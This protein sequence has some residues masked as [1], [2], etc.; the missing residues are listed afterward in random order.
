MAALIGLPDNFTENGGPG[1]GATVLVCLLAHNAFIVT[2]VREHLKRRAGV[3][4]EGVGSAAVMNEGHR[5]AWVRE[6]SSLDNRM[7]RHPEAV[8]GLRPIDAVS[9]SR[10]DATNPAADGGAEGEGEGLGEFLEE[11]AL[12]SATDTGSEVQ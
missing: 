8:N 5:E 6:L 1:G 7:G 3:V 2:K 11:E 12:P 10:A 4:G 9:T